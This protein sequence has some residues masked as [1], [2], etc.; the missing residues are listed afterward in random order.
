MIE[1]MAACS[2][3]LSPVQCVAVFTMYM[4][5]Q[6]GGMIRSLPLYLVY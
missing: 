5:I 3:L 2:I 6:D 4:Y 1:L